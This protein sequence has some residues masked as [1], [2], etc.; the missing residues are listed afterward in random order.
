MGRDKASLR[1][2]GP[3]SPR[4]TLAERTAAILA[5]S[6]TP[7]FEVGPGHTSLP[8]VAEDPPGQ[9]P[10]V[11]L[12]AGWE[13]LG[14]AGWRGPVIVVATDLP[15]LTG[16]MLE[17]L[18]DRPGDRSVVPVASGRVQPL[19]ARYSPADLDLAAG[20]VASGKR[21]MTALIEAAAPELVAEEE[22][23]PAAGGAQV[24]TDVDTPDDVRR[25]TGQ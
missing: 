19:C 11:A 9:G 16:S 22:W 2:D 21:A 17:W 4:P 7:A 3:G 8:T 13:A 20:L 5:R 25:M 1:L 14:R 24:L 10:L 6:C 15:R 18:T 12:V 23:A